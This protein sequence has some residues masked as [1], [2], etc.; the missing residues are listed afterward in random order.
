MPRPL[1]PGQPRPQP[2]P[3]AQARHTDHYGA[4]PQVTRHDNQT[5]K[6][7]VIINRKGLEKSQSFCASLA[8]IMDESVVT[9]LRP[10]VST[11]HAMCPPVVSR[12][13]IVLTSPLESSASPEITENGHFLA[14]MDILSRKLIQ[15]S[16]AT[17]A[18][19]Q[20]YSDKI[21]SPSPEPALSSQTT[22]SR[23]RNRR[24]YKTSELMF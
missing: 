21:P 1:P 11:R 24:C 23:V 15:E 20:H 8:P 10:G 16:L 2:P 22:S 17:V 6:L 5:Y 12:P 3:G 18:V 14:S 19:I 9:T 13:E 4:S 7:S